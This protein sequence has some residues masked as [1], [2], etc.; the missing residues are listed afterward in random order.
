[1]TSDTTFLHSLLETAVDA[2][3]QA[4][5]KA[6]SLMGK[7]ASTV[8][9]N[10]EIVTEADHQCQ[11]LIIDRIQRDF[12]GHGFIGEEGDAGNC[13][14]QPP[15]H[16]QDVWWVIDPIDGTNNYIHGLPQFSVSIAAIQQGRPSVGVVYDPSTDCLFTA[17]GEDRPL[18]N[19]APMSVSEETLN[20]Y[21]SIGIDSH[22]GGSIPDWLCRIMVR[23]RF[24]NIGTTA[25][26]LA[27][28]GKGAY[29]ATILFMPKLWDIAAGCLLAENAGAVS[30]DWAGK[31]LWPFD[32]ETYEGGYIPCVVGNPGVHK[33]ILAM[34][35][36]T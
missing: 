32:L 34:I 31:P 16:D 26:H 7:V 17:V 8:K 22:F 12:P 25:L 24:R 33:D 5:Q 23:C 36:S 9:N 1:M 6:L 15:H 20:A 2:G 21:C 18:V 27:Y 30:T 10:R 14:K 29:A 3:R 13:F 28:T 19:G 4:G 35:A 11:R